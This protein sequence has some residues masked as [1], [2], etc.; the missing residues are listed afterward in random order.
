MVELYEMKY[1]LHRPLPL[2]NKYI[3][4]ECEGLEGKFY[5]VNVQRQRMLWRGGEV[6]TTHQVDNQE[7]VWVGFH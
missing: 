7:L 3:N 5:W 1:I 2:L 4:T 6:A